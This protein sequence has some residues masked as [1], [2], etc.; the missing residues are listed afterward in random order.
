MV[1]EFSSF[2]RMPK[3]AF[4]PGDLA[5]AIKDA[6]FLIQVGQ[7]DID[8]QVE[9]DEK[10][11]TGRFDARLMA[12]AI[13]NI[14]KNGTEGIAAL[15]PNEQSKGRILVRGCVRDETIVVD[16]I[17]NGIGLPTENRSRLLEPYVTTREKGT[18]LGLAIVRKIVEEH[19]GI[20]E[21][22]DAP[23]VAEGGH[24][25][26]VRIT[27]PRIDIA[28]DMPSTAEAPPIEARN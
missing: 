8:F 4:A 28:S 25:A 2:A 11:L 6:V 20:L 5:E 7:P 24:G 15:P 19:G 9:L 10:P 26:C 12:Q 27:L 13:T 21:L 17:D 1:D 14:V 22:L 23:E 16:V 3:P 18:G